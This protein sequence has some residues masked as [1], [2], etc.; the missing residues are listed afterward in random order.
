MDHWVA[1]PCM[2]FHVTLC[3]LTN[4]LE[5]FLGPDKKTNALGPYVCDWH[6]IVVVSKGPFRV[7]S[8]EVGIGRGGGQNLRVPPCFVPCRAVPP[9]GG[10]AN[11]ALC[12]GTPTALYL[13]LANPRH[14]TPFLSPSSPWVALPQHVGPPSGCPGPQ[15]GR[16]TGV[17]RWPKGGTTSFPFLAADPQ[18]LS[19]NSPRPPQTPPP[20]FFAKPFA[21][22]VAVLQPLTSPPVAFLS[23]GLYMPC[24]L[25][26]TPCL[27]FTRPPLTLLA[28]G[29]W[30][31]LN[32]RGCLPH[33]HRSR[34]G[35]SR[36]TVH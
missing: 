25:Q 1:F 29:L 26:L 11:E 23:C 34:L 7:G 28:V 35:I 8:G 30:R 2:S 3:H 5:R 17:C 14:N 12:H 9:W 19:A 32:H 15:P 13:Q 16:W 36:A 22:S 27:Q 18:A 33:G 24:N 21:P 10:G 20:P 6:S 4:I 31:H